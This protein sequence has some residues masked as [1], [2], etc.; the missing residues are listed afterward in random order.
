MAIS[1]RPT[2]TIDGKDI[3][4]ENVEFDFGEDN[5][6]FWPGTEN[7]PAIHIADRPQP[8]IRI[9]TEHAWMHLF[10]EKLLLTCFGRT[11]G[12]DVTLV[13]GH[14]RP[15]WKFPDEPFVQYEASDESWCRYFGIGKE[16][17]IRDSITLH[18][19]AI[20]QTSSGFS[21]VSR[22]EPTITGVEV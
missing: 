4:V 18:D 17:L 1:T 2:L 6:R 9:V 16:V 3:P 11:E 15:V 14:P 13:R 8:S 12:F 7:F 22:R 10:D 5:S 20:D 21:F 19:C